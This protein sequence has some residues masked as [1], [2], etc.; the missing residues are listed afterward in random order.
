[1]GPHKAA[2]EFVFHKAVVC[3]RH[4]VFLRPII[5]AIVFLTVD[6]VTW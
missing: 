6:Y 3:P 2:K 4:L 5:E 1:M